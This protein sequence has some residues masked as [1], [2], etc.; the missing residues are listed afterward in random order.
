MHMDD[1][2]PTDTTGILLSGGEL[3]LNFKKIAY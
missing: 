2:E 3:I 1:D